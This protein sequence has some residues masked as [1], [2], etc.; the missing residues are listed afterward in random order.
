MSWDVVIPAGGTIDSAYATVIGSP[1]RALAP[2]AS[3]HMPVLQHIVTT[4]R[5]TGQISCVICIAPE[6]VQ[7]KVSGVDIWLPAGASGPENIRLGLR[8]A[9]P[10]QAALVCTSDLPLITESAV[11][12]FLNTC[13]PEA[14]V[15]A[16]LVRA[17]D[18]NREFTDAPPSEF[19]Q[20]ADL[21]PVTLAGLFQIQPALLTRHEAL[22]EKL[23]G[24]R[25]SQWHLAGIVGLDLL[26]AWATRSLTLP[27]IQHRAERLLSGPLQIIDGTAPSLAY[28]IDTADDYTYAQL[29]YG[30]FVSASPAQLSE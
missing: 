20:L 4:L 28:D 27:K 5:A 8:Y 23:F 26:W 14:F 10:N 1:H 22:L 16:G 25:K 6:A 21:G 24:A 7:S 9:A 13:D 11:Q 18:Y 3:D 29:Y 12:Q 15:S 19:V 17:D 2:L 30:Q